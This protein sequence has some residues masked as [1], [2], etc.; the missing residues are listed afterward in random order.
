M[1]CSVRDPKGWFRS[2]ALLEAVKLLKL[3]LLNPIVA[4]NR[5]HYIFCNLRVRL[6]CFLSFIWG[7]RDGMFACS[8]LCILNH[9]S[10]RCCRELSGMCLG[11]TTACGLPCSVC[12]FTK[13]DIPKRKKTP[14]FNKL[15]G[16][17]GWLMR[18]GMQRHFSQRTWEQ[19]CWC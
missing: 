13:A 11:Y 8:Q 7:P 3:K 2:S 16:I 10:Q 12:N 5:P 19:R 15:V 14:C 6:W 1:P 4:R 18:A 17:F 9:F